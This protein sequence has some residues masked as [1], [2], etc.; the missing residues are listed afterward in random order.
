[1]APLRRSSASLGREGG[2]HVSRQRRFL[3]HGFD[4]VLERT[5]LLPLGRIDQPGEAS[6]RRPL[7][8]DRLNEL[9]TFLSERADDTI[10]LPKF[11]MGLPTISIDS[12]PGDLKRRI[13]KLYKQD[14]VLLKGI[15]EPSFT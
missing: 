12:I 6:E 13:C 4:L 3:A 14:Y 10:T 5:E 9:K 15:Y 8:F 11:K 2:D 1:M 7:R